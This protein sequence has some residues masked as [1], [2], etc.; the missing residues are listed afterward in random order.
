L[1]SLDHVAVTA[2]VE[3]VAGWR[4]PEL[5]TLGEDGGGDII[6]ALCGIIS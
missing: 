4:F 2:D 5:V 6:D 3:E 1:L